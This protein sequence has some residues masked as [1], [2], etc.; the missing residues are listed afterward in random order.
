MPVVHQVGLQGCYCFLM[1]KWIVIGILNFVVV[2][3]DGRGEGQLVWGKLD[4]LM[5][6]FLREP[7][8]E[9]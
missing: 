9:N 5:D 8:V 7:Q 2:A 3:R 4:L 6:L 1:Q